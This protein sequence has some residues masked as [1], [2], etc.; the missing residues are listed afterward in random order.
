MSNQNI[1][2]EDKKHMQQAASDVW[3]YIAADCL[4]SVAQDKGK[5]V[6]AVKM[7]KRDVIETVLDAGRTDELLKRRNQWTPAFMDG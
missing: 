5:K 6:Y 4:E 1:T 7:S 2:D 3:D